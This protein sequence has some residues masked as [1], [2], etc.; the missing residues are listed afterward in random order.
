MAYGFNDDKTKAEINCVPMPDY[1]TVQYTQVNGTQEG[2]GSAGYMYYDYT[3]P[4]DG[5][6]A[7]LAEGYDD[8]YATEQYINVKVK[9]SSNQYV[10]L[11]RGSMKGDYVNSTRVTGLTMSPYFYFKSGMEIELQW[12]RPDL[13]RNYIRI[14]SMAA[15]S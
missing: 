13:V 4:S 10:N 11:W 5:Y 3:V 2:S 9:N 8:E 6:Y 7:F 12:G 15:E 14:Y 1:S